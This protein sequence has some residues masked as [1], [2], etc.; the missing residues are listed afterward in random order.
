MIRQLR[1]MI[2]LCLVLQTAACAPS[3]APTPRNLPT[4]GFG[5]AW[6]MNLGKKTFVVLTLEKMGDTFAG[7]LSRP[8]HF[9]TTNGRRFSRFSPGVTSETVVRASIQGDRLHLVTR[10]K[11]DENEYDMTLI[12]QSAASVTL[13]DTP[14]EPWIFTRF[15]GTDLPSVSTDWDPKRSYSMDDNAVSNSEMQRLYEEDQHARKDF[16]QF[17]KETETI[18]RQDEERRKQTRKLLADGQLHTAEDFT[19]AAFIFQHG[20]TP[21]DFLLAHTLAMVAAAKGDE[22]A[23]WISTATLDRY[24]QSTARPQIFGT[25]IKEKADHT[26]TLEPYNRNLVDDVLRRELGVQPL[27]VQQEQLADR[28]KE[29]REAAAAKSK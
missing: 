28:T 12:G 10:N 8:E 26:A 11:E 1:L 6:V 13:T 17:A 20:T 19:R 4:E 3:Q 2:A 18:G 5:G 21:D 23:L 29:F 7:T 24:L 25:Q 9:Q 16:A 14:I 22:D 15:T 27:A